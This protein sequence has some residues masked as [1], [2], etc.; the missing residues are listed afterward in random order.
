MKIVIA[1]DSFKGSCSAKVVANSIE[2]GIKRIIKNCEVIK[3]PIADGGEGTVEALI[4]IIG[5]E[6][7]EKTVVG[8]LG[9]PVKAGFGILKNGTAVIELAAAS[10]LPLV[11]ENLRNPMN[12]TTFGTGQLIL[13]AIEE[14]CRKIIVG[15]GGSATN[16]GGAGIA[17]AMGVSLKDAEGLELGFGG[18]QL[19]QLRTISTQGLDQ[20][21]KDTEIIIACDVTNPLCGPQGASYIYG[22]QKGGTPEIIERLDQN[23]LHYAKVIEAELGINMKDIPGTGAAGGATVPLLLF[24]KGKIE[25]GIKVIL[26]AADIDRHFIDA[27][28]VITGEGK[29][30]GQSILGK[31]PVG[32][33]KRAK[34]HQLPVIAIVGGIG[35]GAEDCYQHGIDGIM[36]IVP[37]PVTLSD[38]M[39]H[40]ASFIENAAERVFRIMTIGMNIKNIKKKS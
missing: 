29:I 39:E 6:I 31:V 1:P 24:A 17:Q 4:S 14:G 13:A 28:L 36:S 32:V 40:A 25:S 2:R 20:R 26:D 38:A 16:D 34:K 30:D 23:L 37:A 5:G 21:L 27:D 35:S 11:P 9:E 7:K 18:D 22:P 15:L 8:P 12:T 10:G 19:N 33:A 3:I